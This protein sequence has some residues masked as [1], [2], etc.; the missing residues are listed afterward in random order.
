M[1]KKSKICGHTMTS[2]IFHTKNPGL[3]EAW[4]AADRAGYL[5]LGLL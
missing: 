2:M 1:V 5:A 3:L 4:Q